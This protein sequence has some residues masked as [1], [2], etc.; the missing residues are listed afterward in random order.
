MR[1]AKLGTLA[2][3][4]LLALSVPA[5]WAQTLSFQQAV[6]QALNQNPDLVVS[7]AQIDQAEAAMR[8][9]EGNKKPRLNLSVTATNTN[10]ALNA[11]G[12]K[13]SQRNATFGDFGAGEFNPANPNVL[14]IAP[15]DLNHPDSVTNVNPR[16][17]LLIPVYNGGMV[18]SYVEQAQAYVRAAQSG[19]R[20]ARQQIIKHV[21]MA[22]QGVHTAR[23]YIKV[24]EQGKAAA[25][26]YVRITEKLHKQGMAV[27]SD[28]LSAKVNLQEVKLKLVEARNAE[29]A[30]LDQLHLLLG[31]PLGE[32]LDV[33]A[34]VTPSLLAGND[35]DLR[36]QALDTHAGLQALR[37]Q[38]QGAG[39]AVEA[40]RASYKPQFNVMLRGDVNDEALGF[41]AAS[42]TVAGVLSWTAFDGGVTKAGVDRAEAQRTELAARL[43]QAEDGIAY[44]VGDAR[45][46]ALE[47]EEKIAARETAMEQAAEAQRLVQKR[48]ENGVATLIE[49]L[50]TQAQLDKARADL[51]AA[52]YD[53]AVNRAE[54][55][56]AVGVLSPE[57]L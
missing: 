2:G 41:G 6:E 54:L 10:D 57:Q 16:V 51:V 34:P 27:K 32:P 53:L 3:A 30:A 4:M 48:Y 28:A 35:A 45:R 44:Q 26:E 50:S 38:M 18:Q 22:Y 29:A 46:K 8:Q 52:R 55:K 19:D 24:A 39:S 12:L 49:L 47:A 7:R 37:S 33:G 14:S 21:L 17:E 43:R 5:A 13:L 25:E 31:K 9:A 40:A 56:R 11:F 15:H 1:A 42:Y 23:A 36:L 20:L